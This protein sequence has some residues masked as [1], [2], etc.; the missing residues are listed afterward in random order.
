MPMIR[1]SFFFLFFSYQRKDTVWAGF[2]TQQCPSSQHSYY[3]YHL[4]AIPR[5]VFPGM[6][7]LSLWNVEIL[8]V[9]TCPSY[10]L[11]HYFGDWI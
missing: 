6:F 2:I 7:C 10:I 5:H 8:W 11:K 9:Y 1:C 3:I 4:E